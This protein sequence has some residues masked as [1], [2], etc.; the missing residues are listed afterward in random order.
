MILE[1]LLKRC[2]HS[3]DAVED[4]LLVQDVAALLY[5]AATRRVFPEIMPAH[6]KS[7]GD[8]DPLA[9]CLQKFGLTQPAIEPILPSEMAL[10]SFTQALL[11]RR[12]H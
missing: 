9:S 6:R 12:F 4:L 8:G 7:G 10:L 1:F 11:R 2:S 3:A 5:V